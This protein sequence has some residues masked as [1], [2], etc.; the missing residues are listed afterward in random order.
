MSALAF[1]D[2]AFESQAAFRAILRAIASPGADR[3][4]RA[5]PRA[6][7]AAFA[8]RGGG[9]PRAR[10]FRDAALDRALVAEAS[11][12]AAYLKFHTGAPLA[13]APREAAFALVDANR[14]FSIS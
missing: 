7:V 8:G 12:M 6:A 9:D 2:P 11:E 4:L 1:A 14:T 5:R 10:R 13:A 3:T